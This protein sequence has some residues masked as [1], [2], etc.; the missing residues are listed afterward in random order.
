MKTTKS[1][2]AFLIFDYAL[3]AI[4]AIVALFPLI[5][6]ASLSLSRPAFVDAGIVSFLPKG[7]NFKSFEYIFSNNAFF[8]AFLN[9][10]IRLVTGVPLNVLM[11]VLI[12]YPL[13]RPSKYLPSRTA[14]SWFF[15]ITMLFSGGMIPMYMLVNALNIENTMLALILPGAVPVFSVVLMINFF[16]QVP[17]E[18]YEAAVIDGAGEM[19]VMFT[20]YMPLSM[21]SV[22]TIALFSIVAHWNSWFDGL[23][24]MDNISKYPL[25]TYLQSVVINSSQGNIDNILDQNYSS[26][27]TVD[28]ARLFLAVIPIAIM[29][30]PLQKYFVKG[31]TLGGVKG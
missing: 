19:R 8:I 9:S 1:R 12:A 27:E 28:A 30:L 21:P 17:E 2:K 15:I 20:I 24:Y 5:H 6:L 18:L 10:M 4:Y 3:F 13:S 25:Q 7:L 31:L 26:Q 29:Y 11:V 14:Y 23:I 16:R 22:V